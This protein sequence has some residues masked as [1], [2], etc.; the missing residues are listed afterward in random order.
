[1]KQEIGTLRLIYTDEIITPEATQATKELVE[2]IK[3]TG[4][5][6]TP[7][8]V[9]QTKG[10]DEYTVLSGAEIL[11]A[12][13]EAGL[14]KVWTLIA[15]DS[16][17]TKEAVNAENKV[18]EVK[19][20]AEIN[21]KPVIFGTLLVHSEDKKV[22][23]KAV[24]FE[25]NTSYKSNNGL[26][27]ITVTDVGGLLIGV[28]DQYALF[29]KDEEKEIEEYLIE[30]STSYGYFITHDKYGTIYATDKA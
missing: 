15:D 8:I 22:A 20:V 7:V 2:S 21:N 29:C 3:K 12:C 25:L 27:T 18:N 4:R 26:G 6:W 9:V 30:F 1:M 28:N 10:L 16:E 24:K 13:K 5:N 11:E 23:D 19:E 14:T 17:E